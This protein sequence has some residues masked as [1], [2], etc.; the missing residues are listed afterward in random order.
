MESKNIGF[1]FSIDNARFTV[2]VDGSFFTARESD[3]EVRSLHYHPKYELYFVSDSLVITDEQGE[4]DLPCGLAVI[5]PFYR[6][7]ARKS[8]V[9]RLLFSF[10]IRGEDTEFS[11]F[12]K[13]LISPEKILL[14]KRIKSHEMEVYFSELGYLLRTHTCVNSEIAVATL[15]LIFFHLFIFSVGIDK[16][17]SDAHSGASNTAII[18]DTLS[19]Y[20]LDPSV[21]L[22]LEFMSNRLCLS[23]K[24]TARIIFEGYKASLSELINERR[25]AYALDLVTESDLYMSEIAERA[26]FHSENYFFLRFKRAFGKTPLKYRKERKSNLRG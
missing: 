1:C 16:R 6:H 23:K 2:D 7:R 19:R 3:T 11:A 25:L 21:T 9:Y 10:E 20:A 24:Q 14:F 12:L 17:G 18:E 8:S 22:D 13:T 4:T 15:K 5:P 26:N